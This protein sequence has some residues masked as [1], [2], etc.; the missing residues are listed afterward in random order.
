MADV[1]TPSAANVATA[2][3]TPESKQ[4]F[5]RPEKPDEESYKEELSKAEKAH[6]TAQEKFV[7]RSRNLHDHHPPARTPVTD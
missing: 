5:V 2:D 1:A 3:A 7:S 4:Q 6:A